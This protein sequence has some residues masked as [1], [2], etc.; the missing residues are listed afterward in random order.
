MAASMIPMAKPQLAIINDATETDKPDV[1]AANVLNFKDFAEK[2]LQEHPIT[3]TVGEV[4][5]EAGTVTDTSMND[6]KEYTLVPT[7]KEHMWL[8]M[9]KGYVPEQ[10]CPSE[11]MMYQ[12][13]FRQHWQEVKNSDT[14]DTIYFPAGTYLW[15]GL[16]IKNWD[17]NGKTES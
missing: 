7:G 4:C 14:L 3:D 17:G 5:T 12:K 9:Q 10:A 16:S 8:M 15:S 2:Y 1:T 11:K 13:H 6:G